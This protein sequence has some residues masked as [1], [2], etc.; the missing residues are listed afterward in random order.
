[1][2]DA[3]PEARK[4]PKHRSLVDQSTALAACLASSA[5][6]LQPA[7]GPLDTASGF[8]LAHTHLAMPVPKKS[9]CGAPAALEVARVT[10]LHH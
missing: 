6:P 1:M 8:Q 3:D 5:P 4:N 9:G 10:H 2:I 7:T